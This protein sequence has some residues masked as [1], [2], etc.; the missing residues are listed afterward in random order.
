M[1]PQPLRVVHLITELNTGGAEQ[2][3]HKVT[4]RMN[5]KRFQSVVVS[6]TDRGTLG[7]KVSAEG[8]PVF[9]LGMSLGRPRPSGFLKL[10]HLLKG[11][12]LE[13]FGRRFVFLFAIRANFPHQALGK[14][15]V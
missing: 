7:E 10:Y 8:I 1:S 12:Q 13:F 15:G 11:P 2:M 9:H 5:R 14:N 6:M 3:L 4:A